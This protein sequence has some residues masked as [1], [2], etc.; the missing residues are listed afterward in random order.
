MKDLLFG[1]DKSY[2]LGDLYDGKI[3]Q[4]NHVDII[5][6]RYVNSKLRDSLGHLSQG[7]KHHRIDIG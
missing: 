5:V 1:Y 4:Y 6:S 2:L 7:S 3:N